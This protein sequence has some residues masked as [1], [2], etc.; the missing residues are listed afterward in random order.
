[1]LIDILNKVKDN[2]S[3]KYMTIEWI[4]ALI[5]LEEDDKVDYWLEATF[6]EISLWSCKN[7]SK[8]LEPQEKGYLVYGR[9]ITLEKFWE[10]LNCYRT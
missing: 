3:G 4:K 5:T 2:V 10:V 7:E 9:N 6:D 8:R 1:M